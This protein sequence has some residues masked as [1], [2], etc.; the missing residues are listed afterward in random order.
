MSRFSLVE[1]LRDQASRCP[2]KKAFVFLENGHQEAAS[3][4]YGQLDERAQR[5]ALELSTVSS[6]GDRGILLYEAGLEPLVGLF[7]CAYA[8]IVAIPSP[9]PESSRLKRTLPRLRAIIEDADARLLLGSSNIISMLRQDEQFAR[10]CGLRFVVTDGLGKT[11]RSAW[12]PPQ[13]SSDSLAYLQYTSGSTSAPKG[14]MISHGNVLHH[15]DMARRTCGY[16]SE[17][18]TVAWMPYYHDYGLIEGLLIPLANGTP[19]Y[20]MSPFSFIK[21]PFHWLNAITTFRATHSQ[22]PNF[23]YNLCVRRVTDEQLHQLDLSNWIVAANG[24]EPINPEVLNQF[25]QRFA[26]AGFQRRSFCPAYG[27]AEATL[28]VSFTPQQEEPVIEQ[29]DAA[30][31]EKGVVALADDQ[32]SSTRRIVGCGTNFADTQVEIVDPNTRRVCKANRV[33]EIWV[34]SPSVASGYWNLDDATTSTFRATLED[35]GK[36]PYLRTGDLGFMRSGHL[37]ITGRLKDV[38]IIRGSN[39]YPQDIEWTVQESHSFLRADYGAAFSVERDGEERLV[40]VQELE[41]KF[42][43]S[44]S[45]DDVFEAVIRAVSESH[46]VDVYAIVLARRGTLPKTTSGKI[47]R[48]DCRSLYE[49]QELAE[50]TSWT[51]GGPVRWRTNK[52]MDIAMSGSAHVDPPSERAL[53]S[54]SKHASRQR[55]DDLITWL[56]DYGEHRINS[57][58]MDERR[59]VPPKIILDFGNKGLFGMQVPISDGGLGLGYRDFFR[60]LEQTAA[61]DTTLAT[62]VFLNNTNGTRPIQLFARPPLREEIL[63]RLASG[64]EL[65]AFCLSEPGAGSNLAGL[66][67]VAAPNEHGWNIRGVKRWNYSA[68]AGVFS[69]FARTVDAKGRLGDLTGFVV[70]E[71]DKGVQIGPE[72]LTMGVRSILQNEVTFDGV[73]VSEDRIL[74]EVGQGMEIANDAL[75]IG[76]LSTAA[77]SLGAMKRAAQLMARYASRRNIATGRL[78]DNPLTR[79]KLSNIT[80]GITVAQQL[81]EFAADQLDQGGNIPDELAMIVKVLATDDLNYA[82]SELIQILGGRGYMENNMAPQLFRDAKLLS[83]GEGPNENLMISIGR[84]VCHDP[85]IRDLLEDTLDGKSIHGKLQQAC[86]QIRDQMKHDLAPFEDR[87]SRTTYGH[88]LIGQLAMHSVAYAVCAQAAHQADNDELKIAAEWSKWRF[89]EFRRRSLEPDSVRHVRLTQ[90][91]LSQVAAYKDEIGEFEPQAADVDTEVDPMLRRS[92][93]PEHDPVSSQ[94]TDSV[95]GMEQAQNYPAD[96]SSSER[97]PVESELIADLSADEKRELLGRLLRGHSEELTPQ[98]K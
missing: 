69:V 62:L 72:A 32:S 27:L 57:R 83:I 55:A 76:R 47:Q 80:A 8:G 75:C 58:L 73:Q 9:P 95:G 85:A 48:R 64:R 59:C 65:G 79:I 70:R 98:P 21:R 20:V 12:T 51:N 6:P 40:V 13:L 26:K 15:A 41:R 87:S 54:S 82:V 89:E 84:G 97:Q 25:C 49:N 90:E 37:F 78:I 33:G 63:P 91:L 53:D 4:T 18:V 56:R 45:F 2:E 29:V 5:V 93:L 19:C 7:G 86:D 66:A 34:S 61:I 42:E 23:A 38:I 3:L 1:L 14:V 31:L 24:A 11:E 77:V 88:Q 71:D 52:P 44:D 39:H 60:V 92:E 22:A 81:L 17:S 10:Q 96:Q 74:G 46:E 68:W 94:T 50:I 67:T 43:R 16:N 30:S 36:G 35:G 28:M